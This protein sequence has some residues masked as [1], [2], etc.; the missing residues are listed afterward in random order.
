MLRFFGMPEIDNQGTFVYLVGV[1]C[2]VLA[3]ITALLVFSSALLSCKTFAAEEFVNSSHNGVSTYLL[4]RGH[5]IPGV[6]YHM[7]WMCA[8]DDHARV[9]F[10]VCPSQAKKRLHDDIISFCMAPH[11]DYPS[12]QPHCFQTKKKKANFFAGSRR[13][14]LFVVVLFLL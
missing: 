8:H 10:H 7:Y 13:L 14:F 9:R 2:L 4:S 11:V 3:L 5:F 6:W 1:W 12:T